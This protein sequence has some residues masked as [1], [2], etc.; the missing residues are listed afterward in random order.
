MQHCLTKLIQVQVGTKFEF[1]AL[2]RKRKLL[3]AFMVLELL[4]D[5]MMYS[6]EE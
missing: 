3:V 2:T 4:E 6:L 5:R 1:M